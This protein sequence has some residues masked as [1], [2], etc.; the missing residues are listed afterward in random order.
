MN[1]GGMNP[2]KIMALVGGYW[3]AFTIQAG[4]KLE[5]FTIIGQER[6]TG[7]EVAQRLGGDVRGVTTL[8]NALTG[9]ELLQKSE[10]KFSNTSLSAIYLSKES[11]KYLGHIVMHQAHLVDSWKKLDEAVISG[12]PTRSRASSRGEEER[13]AFLMGMFNIAMM[14]A[15]WVVKEVDLADRKHF[16]DLGGGPGTWAI[17]FCL[18]NPDLRATVFDLP[19]T[20]P[21]AEKTIM[22]FNL[23]DRV[24]FRGGDYLEDEITG[25]YDTVWMSQIL[26]GE[27]PESCKIIIRKA[28]SV[29]E[30][31]GLILVHD[32]LLNKDLAGPLQ[33]ALFSLNMLAGTESGRAYS[34]EQIMDMLADAG[35]KDLRRLPIQ[36]P[37]Q[38]GIIAGRVS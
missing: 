7:R 3:P 4:V 29:L 1:E 11:P 20:R 12:K 8:L 30:P 35:A 26:H 27:G 33:P 18:A 9:M 31:E 37:N 23:S 24:V 13:K 38:S 19:G 5:I 36:T 32:L 22:R 21:F 34:E 6:L 28:L 14:M 17:H 15:P 16:L 25:H 2:G 10:E